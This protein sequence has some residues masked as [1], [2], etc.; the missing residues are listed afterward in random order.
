MTR[1]ITVLLLLAAAASTNAFAQALHCQSA[2][3]KLE[4]AICN[5]AE[6]SAKHTLFTDTANNAVAAQRVTPEGVAALRN[7]I[8]RHCRS[9]KNL[10]DCLSGQITTSILLLSSSSVQSA[11]EAEIDS[12]RQR[13]AHLSALQQ[14]LQ[15]AREQHTRRG[16]PEYLIA[17]LLALLQHYAEEAQVSSLAVL[18]SRAI[19]TELL[20]GCDDLNIR[21]KW[22]KGLQAYGWACPI[23][24]AAN[25]E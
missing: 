22:N 15:E 11:V 10:V 16:R 8:A 23:V 6:L 1:T 4:Q 21:S 20:A 14:R 17:T 7:S 24:Q 25:L 2:F 13:A 3:T 5:S 9:A 18:E 12:P 19:R